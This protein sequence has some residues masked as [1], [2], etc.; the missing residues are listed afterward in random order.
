[1]AINIFTINRPHLWVEAVPGG[2]LS[3][4]TY[5]F[6]GWNSL[7]SDGA[8]APYYGNSPSV[9]SEQVSVTTDAT[10]NRI[11]M[12]VYYNGGDV[13][14]YADA[15]SGLVTVTASAHG[16]SNGDSVWLRGTTNYTGVYTI[17]NVTTNTFDITATWVSDDGA[18]KWFSEPGLNTSNFPTNAYSTFYFKWD[19]YSMLRADGSYFQWNNTNNPAI[20]DEWYP[21]EASPSINWRT[22]GH[23]RW[24]GSY[25]YMGMKE[26]YF[27]TAADGSKYRYL[28]AVVVTTGAVEHRTSNL[29]ERAT[30]GS[31]ISCNMNQ[32]QI[33]LRKHYTSTDQANN[34]KFY[35]LP[36]WMDK[37]APAVLIWIDSTNDYNTW[38]HLIYALKDRTDILGKSIAFGYN[39]QVGATTDQKSA[40]NR[41][42]NTLMLRGSIVQDRQASGTTW[43]D[44][45]IPTFID[46]NLVFYQ[47]I[48][49]T[50]GNSEANYIR[51]YGCN[52]DCQRI[53]YS[54]WVNVEINL[55][56]SRMNVS[57]N[58]FMLNKTQG[59]N[60]S[61]GGTYMPGSYNPKDG[62]NIIGSSAIKANLSKM[63]RDI[64]S[65]GFYLR[66]M[67]FINCTVFPTYHNQAAQ[68]PATWEMR[69]CEFSQ[70]Q[71][72]ETVTSGYYDGVVFDILMESS[73]VST[74]DID[75]TTNCYHVTSP[76]RP[77]G[78]V[79]VSFKYP[80]SRPLTANSVAIF[81]FHETFNIKV[82]DESGVPIE[83]ADVKISNSKSTPDEYEVQTDSNGDIPETDVLIY[84]I[85]YDSTNPDGYSWTGIT[86]D[87]KTTVFNDVTIEIE[88]EGFQ[89]EIVKLTSVLDK[90][91]LAIA[92]KP[93]PAPVQFSI[94]RI[95]SRLFK[96]GKQVISN[97]LLTEGSIEHEAS[98]IEETEIINNARATYRPESNDILIEQDIDGV[99]EEAEVI[100]DGA[101]LVRGSSSVVEDPDPIFLDQSI[102]AKIQDSVSIKAVVDDSQTLSAKI[103]N[104]QS[105]KATISDQESITAK[106][107]N[108]QTLKATIS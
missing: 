28:D 61:N 78:L 98:L 41:S 86:G 42:F 26:V 46:K 13:T 21:T 49:A 37:E 51:F 56:N 75:F 12:E 80:A 79:R 35:D 91:N 7:S 48:V 103:V 81:K 23:H 89:R 108:V 30:G 72:N 11:K 34:I 40:Y 31:T 105:I 57:G 4:A 70:V 106:I 20:D 85:E 8:N 58:N 50:Y 83:N 19:Y 59:T 93:N 76:E 97:E 14:A 38:S 44:S 92:L 53:Q 9:A 55:T 52:I 60:F 99:F 5:Y 15:G 95:L 74:F 69:N 33:A 29:Y 101:E 64:P 25:Y 18:S 32:P 24:S 16:L 62:F 39:N 84:T 65:S 90:Q 67:K 43:S 104:N 102:T 73:F 3:P 82:V 45:N 27:S 54:F 36:D 96:S 10:N 1:M 94:R 66:N 17:S 63:P 77:N 87:S 22:Y 71:S 2:S 47:G 100:T 88:K 6:I 68:Y 107:N